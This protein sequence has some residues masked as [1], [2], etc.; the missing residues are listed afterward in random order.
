MGRIVNLAIR[1]VNASPASGGGLGELDV[2]HRE[3]ASARRWTTGIRM[4]GRLVA[5]TIGESIK[6]GDCVAMETMQSV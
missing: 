2:F 4:Q 6:E 3:H 5:R 1:P